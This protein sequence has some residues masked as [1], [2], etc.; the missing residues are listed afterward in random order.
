VNA[1]RSK[2]QVMIKPYSVPLLFLHEHAQEQLTSCG[3]TALL[4][5]SMEG[6]FIVGAAHVWQELI[7]RRDQLRGRMSIC[8]GMGQR[9]VSLLDIEPVDIDDELDIVVLRAPAEIDERMG[10]KS[11]YRA[12]KW[13]LP[14]A[15]DGETLG[16]LGFPGELRTPTGFTVETNSFYY[17]N[18]CHVSVRGTLLIGAFPEEPPEIVVHV[19]FPVNPVKSLGGISGAPVFALRDGQPV[20]VGVVKRG[21]EGDGA[22]AGLQA[23]P[24]HFIQA[25]GKLRA[26]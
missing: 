14:P 13:P 16:V 20:W 12:N 17:E 5:Q 8:I 25:N 3:G 4:W 18:T 10:K 26:P 9:V 6:R 2:L 21:P 1:P 23:T 15:T 7:A 19:D 22:T 24:S 11:F